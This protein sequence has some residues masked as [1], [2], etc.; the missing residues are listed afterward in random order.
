MALTINKIKKNPLL[1][2][3]MDA[4]AK[5]IAD[6]IDDAAFA[7]A[8][9]AHEFLLTE[10][11]VSCT[12]MGIDVSTD[13]GIVVLKWDNEHKAWRTTY[14][15]EINLTP[16]PKNV[17]MQGRMERVWGLK[18]RI[19]QKLQ[20]HHP[21]IVVIEGFGYA[22]SNSLVTLVEFG[23]A[24]RLALL[25]SPAKMYEVAPTSLKKFILGKGVGKKE[26]V[27]MQVFKKYGYEAKTN[28]L[29]DAYVL[30]QI[31][32]MINGPQTYPPTK[33]QLDVISV[34][35]AKNA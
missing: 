12:V 27:M 17:S 33:P 35:K 26:Q 23:T 20:L 10:T 3:A 30:A 13:T 1:K 6:S 34:V 8:V 24:V 25:E 15:G 32:V 22:N 19:T 16:L 31:G 14:D 4:M 5:N 11:P 2:K 28:N 7:E 9:K 29:A 18:H 21:N